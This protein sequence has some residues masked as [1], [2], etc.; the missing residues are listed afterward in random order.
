M[1][2]VT[3][4]IA[5][6]D[7]KLRVEPHAA[8]GIRVHLHHPASDALGIE[9]R[10]PWCVE[11]VREVSPATVTAEF[12]HLRSTV[13]RRFRLLGMRGTA[14][15]PAQMKR[16]SLLGMERIGDIV[17]QKFARTETGNV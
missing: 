9:L 4:Q 17:L 10:V 13:K 12:D 16:S 6:I 5:E 1:H 2:L 15:D 8:L 7:E 3:P 11:R 14:H